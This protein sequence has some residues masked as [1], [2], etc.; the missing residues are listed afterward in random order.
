VRIVGL[1]VDRG[2]RPVI[3][4]KNH[5]P[6][7]TKAPIPR[8]IGEVSASRNRRAEDVRIFPI[9]V[10]ELKLSNV[11]RHVFGAHF[12]ERTHHAAVAALV[13]VF[14]VGIVELAP[15]GMLNVGLASVGERQYSTKS[16]NAQSLGR[17]IVVVA[18]IATQY[19]LARSIWMSSYSCCS[20]ILL[21]LMHFV[22]Q[23]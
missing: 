3:V 9:V 11:E 6:M 10:A 18:D 5:Q 21:A 15:A 14:I 12:V 20:R 4:P 19:N 8:S 13:F 2:A 1:V 23:L 17:G 22:S 16:S 7:R